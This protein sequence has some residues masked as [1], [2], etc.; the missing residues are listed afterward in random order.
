MSHFRRFQRWISQRLTLR[1]RLALMSGTVLMALSLGLVLF[2]NL[3]ASVVMDSSTIALP[4]ELAPPRDTWKP[5]MPTPTPI[6]TSGLAT[7][8]DIIPVQQALL[9]QIRV[10]SL[11][12]SGY[13]SGSGWDRSLLVGRPRV[14]FPA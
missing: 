14:K 12:G 5:G 10:A 1:T 8:G 3:S 9:G 2:I 7:F 4:P 11:I 13:Y 6:V